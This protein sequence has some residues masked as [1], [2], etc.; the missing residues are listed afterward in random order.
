MKKLMISLA[1]LTAIGA[2]VPAAAQT[3]SYGYNSGYGYSHSNPAFGNDADYRTQISNARY[4]EIV[5][6]RLQISSMITRAERSGQISAYTSRELRTQVGL[7]AARANSARRGGLTDREASI[8]SAQLDQV[9]QRLEQMRRSPR[10]G[11]NNYNGYDRYNDDDNR[12]W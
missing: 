12:G 9:A 1:A 5:Q 3:W 10:Y 2:A 8:A 6:Q 7:I 11:Y 4:N